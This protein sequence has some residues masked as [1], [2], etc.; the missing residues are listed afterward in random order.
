MGSSGVAVV[1]LCSWILG[2]WVVVVAVVVI[3]IIVL[4]VIFFVLKVSTHQ[5]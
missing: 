4:L 3:V 1:A 2:G 5:C